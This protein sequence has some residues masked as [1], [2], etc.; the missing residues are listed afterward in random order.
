MIISDAEF[1]EPPAEDE[2]WNRQAACHSLEKR[3]GKGRQSQL[4]V[5]VTAGMVF[6]RT[7]EKFEAD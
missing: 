6:Q 1:W 2:R 4:C 3:G 7:E 5:F